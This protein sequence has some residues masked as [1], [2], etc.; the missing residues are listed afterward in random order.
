MVNAGKL[1]DGGS[2]SVRHIAAGLNALEIPAARGAG[3]WSAVDVQRV[4]I[5]E[6][7]SGRIETLAKA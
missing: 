3:E 5:G 6:P 4:L 1:R 2:N 7:H